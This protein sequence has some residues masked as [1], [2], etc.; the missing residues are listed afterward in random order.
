M[1]RLNWTPQAKQDL[2]AI[3]E[4]IAQDSNKYAKIQV[5]RLRNRAR[6]LVK[7]PESGRIV[8]ELEDPEIRELILGNYRIV[9]RLVSKDRVDVLTIHHSARTLNL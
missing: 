6:Q 9:Y 1:A 3:A 4:Y 7:F 5:Q 2:I 8:P